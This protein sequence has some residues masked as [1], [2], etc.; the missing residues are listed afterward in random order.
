M[1]IPDVNLLVYAYDQQSPYHKRAAKWWEDL[2]SGEE[3]VGLLHVVV[4]GFVRIVTNPR[5]CANPL[6]TSDAVA[7]VRS[8]LQ[9]PPVQL[10]HPSDEHVEDVLGAFETL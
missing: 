9:Q 2:L 10:L 1:I 4:F 7:V 3:P 6:K 5:I 8:W